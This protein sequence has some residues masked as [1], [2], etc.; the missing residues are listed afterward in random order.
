MAMVEL[1][2]HDLA[3]IVIETQ[4]ANRAIPAR[5]PGLDFD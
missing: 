2:G 4:T 3:A 5:Q 1:H